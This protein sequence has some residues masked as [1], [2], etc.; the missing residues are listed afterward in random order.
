M[1]LVNFFAQVVQKNG[2]QKQLYLTAKLSSFTIY[3]HYDVTKFTE[4]SFPIYFQEV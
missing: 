1:F 2:Y 4:I 3:P